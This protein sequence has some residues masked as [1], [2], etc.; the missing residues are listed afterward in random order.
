MLISL[1]NLT[2]SKDFTYFNDN[3]N[4]HHQLIYRG[5][6]VQKNINVNNYLL[7]PVGSTGFDRWLDVHQQAHDDMNAAIGTSGS[8][9]SFLDFADPRQVKDWVQLHYNEH[10]QLDQVLNLQG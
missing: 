9:L 10:Y 3:N 7:A 8:D 5:L 6:F 1:L 2:S 4:S